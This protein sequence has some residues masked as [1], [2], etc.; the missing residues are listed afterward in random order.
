MYYSAS[1]ILK[2]TCM[3]ETIHMHGLHVCHMHTTPLMHSHVHN[4]STACMLHEHAMLYCT[5]VMA[6]ALHM[7]ATICT[8]E[9]LSN[10]FSM[11][12]C[13]NFIILIT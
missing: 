8:Y 3:N 2:S 4:I 11:H 1:L 5:H 13:S 12:N 7:F 9:E 10:V 6:C